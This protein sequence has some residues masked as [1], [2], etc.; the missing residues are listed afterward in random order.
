M[1]RAP[2]RKAHH[3]DVRSLFPSE[4]PKLFLNPASFDD[5]G[6]SLVSEREYDSDAQFVSTPKHA[7][8]GS[9]RP[10]TTSGRTLSS[11]G[12]DYNK[13]GLNNTTEPLRF[14][15]TPDI[16]GLSDKDGGFFNAGKELPGSD[17]VFSKLHDSQTQNIP[18][19]DGKGKV[20]DLPRP[21]S[22]IGSAMDGSRYN[23]IS[24]ETISLPDW[25]Q[26]FFAPSEG[27]VGTLRPLANNNLNS[28]NGQ[29]P[30]LPQ[31]NHQLTLA[32]RST[33]GQLAQ[34]GS[35]DMLNEHISDIIVEKRRHSVKHPGPIGSIAARLASAESSD[36]PTEYIPELIIEK[37]RRQTSIP[38]VRSIHLCDLDISRVLASSSSITPPNLSQTQ[39]FDENRREYTPSSRSISDQD[40]SQAWQKSAEKIEMPTRMVSQREYVSSI[41]SRSTW[42]ASASIDSMRPHPSGFGSIIY[43]QT[44]PEKRS[45]AMTPAIQSSVAS[46]RNSDSEEEKGAIIT[47]KEP[48]KSKF[49]EHFDLD[50]Q[51]PLEVVFP[52]A[53]RKISIGWMSGGRRL[54]YGYTMVGTDEDDERSSPKD[55]YSLAESERDHAPNELSTEDEFQEHAEKRHTGQQEQIPTLGGTSTH[56]HDIDYH[57]YQRRWS[58]ATTLLRKVKTKESTGSDSTSRSLWTRLSSHARRNRCADNAK[59]ADQGPRPSFEST[60]RAKR[61]HRTK[62]LSLIERPTRKHT[63]IWTKIRHLRSLQ[64]IRRH[65]TD[66]SS[67]R[68]L[69][70]SAES[71]LSNVHCSTLKS[72][73]SEIEN[74]D[75]G[76]RRASAAQGEIH[77]AVVI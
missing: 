71:S 41:Y 77:T 5:F 3:Q 46:S 4:S 49:T 63:R 67:K 69:G 12:R 28:S 26:A 15:P 22:P 48:Q 36:S 65:A 73:T 59:F 75:G 58:G 43:E 35:L 25:Q 34:P 50:Y 57:A 23:R 11:S 9:P 76:K 30:T 2:S 10:V 44:E 64:M 42:S 55:S 29:Q 70:S 19:L 7:A 14:F 32:H 21:A 16:G 51:T 27:A 61:S 18:T 20:I 39:S 52:Y 45:S 33:G 38:G 68:E 1:F 31:Q 17:F 74:I 37:R 62:T 72:D 8:Q 53:P 54:G 24:G 6:S 60:Q 40:G 66:D 13:M 47:T 56:V